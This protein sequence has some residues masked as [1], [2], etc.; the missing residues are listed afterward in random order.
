MNYTE[1]D[2]WKSARVQVKRIYSLTQFFPKEE[3]YGITNEIRGSVVLI[4][5]NVAENE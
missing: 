5:S 3:L 4:P 1:L 2:V